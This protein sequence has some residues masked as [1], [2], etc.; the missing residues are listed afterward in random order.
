MTKLSVVINTRNEEKN[1]ARA[2]ASVKQLADEVVVVDMHSNDKTLD[3]AKKMGAKV[4]TYSPAD[5]VEPAR[6]FAISK[7]KN[8]WILII[9]ADEE[10]I[11]D[12][13]K[14]I[15]RQIIKDDSSYVRIPRKNIIF[16]KWIRHTLWWPDY[17]IR[18]FRKGY[19]SWSEIIHSVPFAKGVG[20]DLEPTERYALLHHNYDSIDQYLLRLIRYTTVQSSFLRKEGYKFNWRDLLSKP[21]KEFL[22]RYFVGEGFKDG[23][24]GLILSLLQSFSE[25]L[26]Y[27]KVWQAEK[28]K[29]VDPDIKELVNEWR[30]NEKDFFFYRSE[31]LS[32]TENIILEKLKSIFRLP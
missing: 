28:F 13:K 10:V 22:G 25:F 4:Y 11:G 24:H 32:R 23:I 20:R 15:K 7:A 18:L 17:Q 19:V 14:V 6:N 30:R 21:S 16:G 2:I 29:E 9:D 12:L 27:I 31:M 1:L 26:V 3:I 8:K 5:Y